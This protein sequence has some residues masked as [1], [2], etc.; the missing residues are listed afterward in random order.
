MP[1]VDVRFFEDERG[2]VPVLD[3]LDELR[4]IDRYGHARCQV[5]IQRLALF[6]WDLRR[7]HT[8]YLGGAIYELRIRVRRVQFRILYFFH[9]GGAVVLT[10]AL[11][12][13]QRIPEIDLA[14]AVARRR[15]FEADPE[16]RTCE[17]RWNNA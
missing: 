15:A 4:R 9:G 2:S 13:E 8:E 14:R 11:T 16:A 6:G 17:K 10:H 5:A 1:G 7:P 12:K 3:W